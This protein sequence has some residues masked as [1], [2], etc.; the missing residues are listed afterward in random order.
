[1][2][3]DEI[4]EALQGRLHCIRTQNAKSDLCGDAAAHGPDAGYMA[5]GRGSV[6]RLMGDVARGAT[7]CGCDYT[8]GRW[9][10]RLL[11]CRDDGELREVLGKACAGWTPAATTNRIPGE[12]EP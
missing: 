6:C 3:K 5:S 12:A 1:M 11:E 7:C 2:T 4:K 8:C 9:V 10:D